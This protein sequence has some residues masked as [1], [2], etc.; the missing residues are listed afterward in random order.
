M[1][2]ELTKTETIKRN[3]KR[4]GVTYDDVARLADVSWRMVSYVIHGQRKSLHVMDAIEK[5]TAGTSR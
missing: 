3:L 5:L 1:E 2:D 4:A